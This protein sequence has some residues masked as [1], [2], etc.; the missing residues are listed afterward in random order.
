MTIDGFVHRQEMR[1]HEI[2]KKIAEQ[3]A[4]DGGQQIHRNLKRW[5]AE[6][7][8]IKSAIAKAQRRGLHSGL[9]QE[10]G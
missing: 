9:T 8:A 3:V 2:N 1:L 7:D 4:K 5:T 6:R 10:Y